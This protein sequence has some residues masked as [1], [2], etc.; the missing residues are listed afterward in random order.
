GAFAFKLL[1]DTMGEKKFDNLLR[2]YLQQ[3]RGK[4]SSIDEFE[5]LA[6]KGNGNNLRFFFAR[7]VEGTG[8]PEF[9][10]DYLIIRTR[11]GKFV[12]RG[13]VKQNYDNLR[14]P[15]EIQRQSE[16]ENK[17]KLVTLD[18]EDASAD[19]NIESEG[20]PIGVIID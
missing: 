6:S 7:W 12:T 17:S 16:G 19:F 14:L 11:S 8:V 15:V 5:K 3:F 18:M 2:T 10:T 13:T 1:R 20:K 9:Q 4:N